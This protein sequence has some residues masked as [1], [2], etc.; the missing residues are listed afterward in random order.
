MHKYLVLVFVLILTM[1]A[2]GQEIIRTSRYERAEMTEKSSDRIN[3]L[4]E[5]YRIPSRFAIVSPSLGDDIILAVYITNLRES[6]GALI[7]SRNIRFL[8]RDE[9]LTSYYMLTNR[10]PVIIGSHAYSL[11]AH[12]TGYKIHYI[13]N[14]LTTT[15]IISPAEAFLTQDGYILTIWRSKKDE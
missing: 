5:K 12:G 11:D 2:S 1:P 7:Q 13:K 14:G 4:R 15:E 8:L 10:E 9:A 3:M 6:N